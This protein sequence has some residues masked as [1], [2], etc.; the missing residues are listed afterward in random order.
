[1]METSKLSWSVSAG[2]SNAFWPHLAAL[3]VIG[4]CLGGCTGPLAQRA[5]RA[6]GLLDFL[7]GNPGEVNVSIE[8]IAGVRGRIETATVRVHGKDAFVAG[9]VARAALGEPRHGAH[10]DVLVLDARQRVIESHIAAYL[11]TSIPH[12]RQG[13]FARSRFT[14]CLKAPPPDGA[15]VKVIF[16]DQSKTSC[17]FNPT[18]NL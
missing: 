7:A 3:L 13:G 2:R 18:P 8:R 1:M 10:V 14:V 6:D 17:K 12:G 16:H 5:Q 9:Y 11:P 15:T 4:G